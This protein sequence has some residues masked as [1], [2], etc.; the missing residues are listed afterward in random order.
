[1]VAALS[2]HAHQHSTHLDVD[3]KCNDLLGYTYVS[4]RKAT[5]KVARRT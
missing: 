4:V 3:L 1:V 5:A 2:D